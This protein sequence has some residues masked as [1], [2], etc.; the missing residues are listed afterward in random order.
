MVGI[1]RI[2][3]LINNNCY[4]GSSKDINKRWER[5]KRDLT[6]KKHHNIILQRAW[7]KYGEYNFIFEIVEETDLVNILIREQYFLD[8]KPTYNI[9]LKS[10][11]GDNLSNNPNKDII[12]KK[13]KNTFKNTID[14]MTDEERKQ[15][16]SKDGILNPNWK[17]GKSFNVCECGKKIKSINKS[18]I[19]CV[20]R[21][22]INNSFYGKKHSNETINKL[23]ESKLGKYFGNQNIPFL[24][25]GV[26]YDSLGDASNKLN[27]PIT[28]IRWRIK[29]KNIKYENYKYL[30]NIKN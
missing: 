1:Y 19:K 2:R 25:D 26:K 4:Y 22:G 10:S 12:I 23:K 28:T 5:H 18:C 21:N 3:N 16:F 6:N 30:D 14:N 9:G 24:I 17:G 11:G 13:I 29:S 7:N 20:N 27:I 8:K 15:K